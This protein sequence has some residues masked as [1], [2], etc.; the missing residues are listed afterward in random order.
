MQC[1]SGRGEDAHQLDIAFATKF[2]R[3]LD[4]FVI[5]RNRSSPI[6]G[7]VIN[8]PAPK[9]H[10]VSWSVS[11]PAD[12]IQDVEQLGAFY[13]D[14]LP[15]DQR[16]LNNISTIITTKPVFTQYYAASIMPGIATAQVRRREE[17]RSYPSSAPDIVKDI[18]RKERGTLYRFIAAIRDTSG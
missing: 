15:Q 4:D 11:V 12:H 9:Y 13:R 3:F 16:K 18:A 17:G 14:K 7:R 8:D 6:L 5:A 2:R 1:A 10:K